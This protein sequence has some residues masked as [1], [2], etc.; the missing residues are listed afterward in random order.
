[1]ITIYSIKSIEYQPRETIGRPTEDCRDRQF[2]VNF[3]R[4]LTDEIVSLF[5]GP[6]KLIAILAIFWPVNLY[7]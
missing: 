1:M 4:W 6:V 3:I 5:E 7:G 2:A